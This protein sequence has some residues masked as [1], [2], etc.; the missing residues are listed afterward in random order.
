METRLPGEAIVVNVDST[1]T[2]I[3]ASSSAVTEAV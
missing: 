1:V 3:P 2:G